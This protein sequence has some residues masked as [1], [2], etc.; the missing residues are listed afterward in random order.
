MTIGTATIDS[1]SFKVYIFNNDVYLDRMAKIKIHTG[2]KEI[3]VTWIDNGW[4][5]R[6]NGYC[7]N[8]RIIT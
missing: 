3:L 6:Q 1:N 2:Y 7:F 4:A 5:Y 8:G